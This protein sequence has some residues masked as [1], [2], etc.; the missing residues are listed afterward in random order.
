MMV[1]ISGERGVGKTL[2]LADRVFQR[3]RQGYFVV[4]NFTHS[5]SNLDCSGLSPEE[6]LDVILNIIDFKDNGFEMFNLHPS[7]KHTG[8]YVAM[9]EATIYFSPEM[10]G[11]LS[12]GNPDKYQRLLN[13]LAQAR[14][15]DVE[16]DYVVQDPAKVG[17]DFRRYT[18]HYKRFRW[19]FKM[20]RM[21]YIPHPRLPIYRRE[22][23]HLLDLVWEEIHDLDAENPKFNYSTITDDHGV[24]Q[25]AESS[26]LQERHLRLTGKYK[27]HILRMY[28]SYQPVAVRQEQYQKEYSPL[29]NFRIVPDTF[30]RER[31]PTLKKILRLLRIPVHIRD[32]FLPPKIGFED[33][34]L[35]PKD[36]RNKIISE[37][38][39]Q[40]QYVLSVA[41]LQRDIARAYAKPPDK[42]QLQLQRQ[43]LR[44]AKPQ[45]NVD[46]VHE[47]DNLKD[48]G[49]MTP[50][51][52]S[53][54]ARGGNF[55]GPVLPVGKPPKRSLISR[56]LGRGAPRGETAKPAQVVT[57]FKTPE[58]PPIEEHKFTYK[59]NNDPKL[60]ARKAMEKKNARVVSLVPKR[61][62]PR[63]T[64][65]QKELAAEREANRQKRMQRRKLTLS[66]T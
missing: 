38:Q 3:R 47:S 41:D 49:L 58:P 30:K 22:H 1:S 15:Y 11:K 48:A 13:L 8:V 50:P 26:T 5:H 65:R 51:T 25:W 36:D 55:G 66:R 64:E 27:K 40:E 21:A 57:P 2:H 7:F 9:D 56:L 20:K 39:N 6:F 16:I 17:K 28:N 44:S 4:T 43:L 42:K 61:K 37:V 29:K 54:S 23:R 45:K 46:R 19:V 24:Q 10:Q 60:A 32:E 53:P 59:K 18:E 62:A 63:V 35:P 31:L 12:K 52:K 14:K 34:V 33:L